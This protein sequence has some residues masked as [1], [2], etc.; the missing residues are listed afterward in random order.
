MKRKS[1]YWRTPEGLAVL[2]GW[3]RDGVAEKEMAARCG[4]PA[5]EL[6][7][8]RAQCP[9]LDAALRLDRTAADYQVEA[10]LWESA[11]KGS[12]TAQIYWLKNRRRAAWQ[13]HPGREEEGG[14]EAYLAAVAGEEF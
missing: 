1:D 8:W 13:D 5:A 12:T 14:L 10:A 4:V 9:E 6:R 3:A 2:A 11:V 7:R